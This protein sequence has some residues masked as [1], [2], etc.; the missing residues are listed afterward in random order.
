MNATASALLVVTFLCGCATSSPLAQ[1]GQPCACRTAQRDQATREGGNELKVVVHEETYARATGVA[2]D[3]SAEPVAGTLVELFAA[4]PA[5]CSAARQALWPS[6]FPPSRMR[7]AACVADAAGGF[8]FRNIPD[9]CYELRASINAGV[10][11]AHSFVRVSKRLGTA[12]PIALR[13]TLGT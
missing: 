5:I 13:L 3:W 6:D 12:A 8:C 7:R 1:G 4:D 9:G 2:E 11:P 10:N